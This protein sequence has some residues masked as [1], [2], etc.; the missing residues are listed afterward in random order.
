MQ[1]GE[2]ADIF[3]SAAVNMNRISSRVVARLARNLLK[4]WRKKSGI[5]TDYTREGSRKSGSNEGRKT[6]LGRA[7]GGTYVRRAT[8]GFSWLKKKTCQF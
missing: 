3:P 7:R 5:R 1:G 4:I 6:F 8:V 2:C